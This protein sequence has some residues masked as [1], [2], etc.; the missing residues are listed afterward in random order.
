[1]TELNVYTALGKLKLYAEI[2]GGFNVFTFGIFKGHVRI[3]I[4]SVLKSDPKND[5]L[6]FNMAIM[7]M[8]LETFIN[9]IDEIKDKEAGTTLAVDQLG[10]LWEN[11]K[12]TDGT[13][14][15]GTLGIAKAKTSDDKIVN[16]IFVTTKDG[17]QFKFPLLPSPYVRL[18]KNGTPI[19][20]KTELSARWTKAYYNLMTNVMA[21]VPE[22]RLKTIDDDTSPNRY[23]VKNTNTT[24]NVSGTNKGEL[25]DAVGLL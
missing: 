21:L 23:Q 11:N 13:M 24:N 12:R 10:P 20:D 25:D 7:P 1:M 9:F 17:M 16:V 3:Y 6:L 18:V 5:T 2:D 14:L 4:K 15:N 19:T 22:A 8:N